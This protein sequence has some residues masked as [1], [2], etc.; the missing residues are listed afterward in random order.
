[1]CLG[2]GIC[3]GLFFLYVD[4]HILG[5]TGAPE[6]QFV[7]ATRVIILADS[8]WAFLEYYPDTFQILLFLSPG[9]KAWL[10][11]TT[12]VSFL[13]DSFC[14][15]HTPFFCLAGIKGNASVAAPVFC[16]SCRWWVG[17]RMHSF[18]SCVQADG[19]TVITVFLFLSIRPLSFVCAPS[20]FYCFPPLPSVVLRTIHCK[21]R[22]SKIFLM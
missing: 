11:H 18:L 8:R 6:E 17:M 22:D 15:I 2:Y 14:S 1:M 16:S 5:Q 13:E 19:F 12:I 7:R 10:Y 20:F 9:K 3:I 21:K 4:S